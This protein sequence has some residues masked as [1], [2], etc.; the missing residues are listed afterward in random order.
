[1]AGRVFQ[2]VVDFFVGDIDIFGGRD[3]I[4]DQF[5]FHVVGGALLLTAAQGGPIEVY[6]SRVD[7]L[8]GQLADKA[9]QAHIHL[10][11][12]QRFRYREVVEL[13]DGGQNF[14]VEQLFVLLVAG[15]FQ[16]LA[17]FFLQ[18]VEGGGVADVFGEFIVQL[19]ELLVS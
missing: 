19:G 4:D 9:F 12:H 11:L 18:L 14:F 6:R 13:D 16:A 1:M 2:L 3:A 8:P 5:S 7:A 17:D 15:G 10:M